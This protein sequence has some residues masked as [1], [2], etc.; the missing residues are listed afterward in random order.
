MV[1]HETGSLW[2]HST[3]LCMKGPLEGTQ[4]R[5]LPARI[6]P[7]QRWRALHPHTRVL[8]GPRNEGFMG[9]FLRMSTDAYGLAVSFGMHSRLVPY[10]VL[11]REEVVNDLFRGAPYVFVFDPRDRASFAFRARLGERELHFDPAPS[12]GGAPRMRDRETRS[13][14]DRMD[15]VAVS[16]ALQGER[17]APALG[18][19]WLVKR[20]QAVYGRGASF[21]TSP[22]G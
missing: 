20:W 1:D 6:T 9:S 13:L 3:G 7:W 16:G 18:V 2:N 5:I 22:S 10:R 17:L 11:R 19:P 15:G 8:L 21:Y 4:L 14:W 12:L